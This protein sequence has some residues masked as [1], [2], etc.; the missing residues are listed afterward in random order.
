[1]DIFYGEVRDLNDPQQAGRIQIIVHGSDNVGTNPIPQANLTW[2]IPIMNNSP[3]LNKVGQ[4][5]N[6]LP[7]TTVV[8]F[9]A[10][11]AKQIGYILGSTHKIGPT[12][13]TPS[14]NGSS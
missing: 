8:G 7:G 13:N 11:D 3:S 10:D 1:M 12:D 4:S 9:W 14:S 6:Y 2:V 5:V